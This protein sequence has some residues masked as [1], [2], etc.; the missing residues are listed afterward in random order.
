[1]VFAKADS[2][3]L[4][5]GEVWVGAHHRKPHLALG[6]LKI[7]ALLPIRLSFCTTST[8]KTNGTTKY[9]FLV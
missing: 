3:S 6:G 5:N 1:M 4:F 7:N 9:L 2:Y 8:A